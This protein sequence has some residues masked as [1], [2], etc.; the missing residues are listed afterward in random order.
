[1][2]NKPIINGLATY[3][4]IRLYNSGMPIIAFLLTLLFTIGPI[5]LLFWL[6]VGWVF[7]K[8]IIIPMGIVL[9]PLFVGMAVG[10]ITESNSNGWTA[11]ISLWVIEAFVLLAIFS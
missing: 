2:A 9:V 10:G 3:G 6:I 7:L 1:M 4:I 8:A 5:G 11:C